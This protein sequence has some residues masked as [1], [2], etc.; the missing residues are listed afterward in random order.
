MYFNNRVLRL[1][2]IV[3][4]NTTFR[5]GNSG[6]LRVYV[7]LNLNVKPARMS[8]KRN[9][10]CCGFAWWRGTSSKEKA[11]L[12]QKFGCTRVIIWRFFFWSIFSLILQTGLVEICWFFSFLQRSFYEHDESLLWKICLL[13]LRENIVVQSFGLPTIRRRMCF[14]CRCCSTS[15]CFADLQ[16]N[17]AV[18]KSLIKEKILSIGM[19][20]YSSCS[21]QSTSQNW[22]LQVILWWFLLTGPTDSAKARSEAPGSLRGQFG[23]G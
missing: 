13:I 9:W 22:H 19:F 7:L 11:S 2:A 21:K 20:T 10:T 8:V 1:P 12:A 5:P 17:Y 4:L 23:T 3:L 16:N 6:L 14:L 15:L 18:N